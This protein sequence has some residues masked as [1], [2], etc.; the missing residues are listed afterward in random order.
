ME[1]LIRILKTNGLFPDFSDEELM[2]IISLCQKINLPK[3]R[4]IFRENQ[5][6]DGGVYLIE[7][8]IVRVTKGS[9]QKEKVLA[10]FG[11]GNIFGEM[12]FLDAKPRSAN[13]QVDEDVI[14]HKLLPGKMKE[15]EKNAPRTAVK[16]LRVFIEKLTAR[17][18]QTDEALIGQEG[19]IIIT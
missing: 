4:V 13:V 14:C 12:S 19:K 9:R 10:M 15:I 16:L 8:G 3:G 5:Q 1:L 11:I 18:R 2:L 6:D 7:E 17:L